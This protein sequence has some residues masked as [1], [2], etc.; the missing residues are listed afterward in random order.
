M[1]NHSLISMKKTGARLD[2]SWFRRYEDLGLRSFSV[3]FCG[4]TQLFLVANDLFPTFSE[5]FERFFEKNEERFT[6]FSRKNTKMQGIRS[7]KCLKCEI[8][9]TLS[10]SEH[11]QSL[12]VRCEGVVCILERSD[13]F[14]CRCEWKSNQYTV[15]LPKCSL[16]EVWAVRML[17]DL[18]LWFPSVI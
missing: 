5:S 2:Y 1:K 16:L 17:L 7:S 18:P 4:P 9:E 11:P 13:G 10:T 12:T 14:C 3:R 8:F 6:V 15:I